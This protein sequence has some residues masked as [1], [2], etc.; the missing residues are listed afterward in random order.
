MYEISAL[1]KRKDE[2][3]NAYGDRKAL[4][5]PPNRAKTLEKK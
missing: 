5:E 1:N 4:C 2:C 3:Q